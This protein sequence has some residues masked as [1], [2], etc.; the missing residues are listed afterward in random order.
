MKFVLRSGLE[1][2]EELRYLEFFMDGFRNNFVVYYFYI[3][4]IIL[5]GL[6]NINFILFRNVEKFFLLNKI[7]GFF[8][9]IILVIRRILFYY[10]IF[11]SKGNN[12]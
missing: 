3:R 7:S 11:W 12:F 9:F 8:V 1:E 5:N 2:V 4:V 6:L 10:I